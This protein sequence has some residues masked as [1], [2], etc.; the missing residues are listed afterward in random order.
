MTVKYTPK[1]VY[2][3]ITSGN[4]EQIKSIFETESEL[5]NL[6]TPL[7]SWLHVATK[8]GHRNIVE[9]LI[10]LGLDVNIKGGPSDV[11]ALYTAA[12]EGN[13]ELLNF[14]LDKGAEIDLT[15]PDRNPL[16]GAIHGGNLN[17]AEKL[18]E[19]GIDVT[20]K[21]TGP[22]MKDMDAVAFCKEWGRTDIEAV[23][24]KYIQRR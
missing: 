1:E 6:I 21:Y 5:V 24:E 4:F 13:L 20:V 23:I 22:T 16:F 8:Y 2:G 12:H 18:L 11:T 7:G 14:F 17:I 9:L 19:H 15:E 3:A 10:G